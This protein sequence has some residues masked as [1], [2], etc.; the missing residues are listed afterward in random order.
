MAEEYEYP[1]PAFHF[2]VSLGGDDLGFSEV[3]GL[4]MEVQEITYRDGLSPSYVS[5]KMSGLPK[6]T[7]IT[8]KRGVISK[9]KEFYTWINATALNK[10]DRRSITVSLLNEEHSPVVTWKVTNAWPVKVEGPSLKADGN[11]VAFESIELAH[12]GFEIE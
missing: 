1:L 8:L 12:E 3:S 2:S 5:K 7:N 11:E 6:F 9:D 10:P 4:T